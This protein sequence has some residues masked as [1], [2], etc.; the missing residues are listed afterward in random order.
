M[1]FLAFTF[2]ST[3]SIRFAH[4]YEAGQSGWEIFE[5]GT[6]TEITAIEKG[7]LIIKDTVSGNQST[8]CEGNVYTTVHKSYIVETIGDFH[9]HVT[10]AL[11]PSKVSEPLS[12]KDVLDMSADIN[13]DKALIAIVPMLFS[14]ADS[15]AIA[16]KIKKTVDIFHSSDVFRNIKATSM[17]LDILSLATTRSIE[18]AQKEVSG[19]RR[20][21]HT[22]YC[23]Q[24]MRYIAAHIKEPINVDAIAESMNVSYGHLSRLFKKQTGFT[25]VDYINKEKVRKM[26]ELLWTKK[27][28]VAEVSQGVG[29]SDEKYAS[30]LFRRYTGL[31]ISS[32]VKL[33][34]K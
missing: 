29:I 26:E 22:L 4:L 6:L 2:D 15:A 8:Y 28:S 5:C 3:P 21:N 20:Y 10:I 9:R 32:Y 24:A 16:L 1:K 30:R 23:Q 33:Y 34:R 12:A 31:T 19:I 17:L 18:A 14:D 13:N 7:S 11:T 27:M 25:L